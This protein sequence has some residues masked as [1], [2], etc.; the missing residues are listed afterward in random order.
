MHLVNNYFLPSH[1][2]SEE[3]PNNEYFPFLTFKH[4]LETP[5][6][7]YIIGSLGHF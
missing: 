4:I 1:K 5:L 2:Q 7:V 3:D 6:K